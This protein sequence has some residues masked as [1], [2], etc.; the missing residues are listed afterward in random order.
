M[1]IILIIMFFIPS[2]SYAKKTSLINAKQEK[3]NEELTVFECEG[4]WRFGPSSHS[5][6][7]YWKL[8]FYNNMKKCIGNDTVGGS[9]EE[10]SL[11]KLKCTILDFSPKKIFLFDRYTGKIEIYDETLES[12]PTGFLDCKKRNKLI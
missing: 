4:T 6:K 11:N 3:K 2:L 7:V 10:H 1:K 5:E 8:D 12:V 9:L